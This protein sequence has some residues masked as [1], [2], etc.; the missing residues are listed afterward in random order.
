MTFGENL[1]YYRKQNNLTQEDLAEQMQV[2]RQSV[3]KWENGEAM[4]DLEKVIKLADILRVNLDDLCGRTIDVAT[5]DS[6]KLPTEL[7]SKDNKRPA[8]KFLGAVLIILAIAVSG[9]CG[10]T[11]GHNADPKAVASQKAYPLSD[12]IKV[13]GLD[14]Y[15][16]HGKLTCNFVPEVYSDELSYTI[17]LIDDYHTQNAYP[18]T[19]KNGVGCAATHVIDGNCYR[20]ILEVS[21]GEDQRTITLADRIFVNGN[22]Y[23]IIE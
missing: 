19:F 11:L 14:F 13:S 1:Q 7:V 9:V 17:L 18:A 5:E 10:Y 21:N 15:A 6:L 22:V 23:E 2:S 16:E 3:S 20:V 4:P 8:V 12:S